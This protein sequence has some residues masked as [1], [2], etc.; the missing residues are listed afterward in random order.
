[1]TNEIKLIKERTEIAVAINGREMPVVK[2]DLVEADDYGLKSEPV[3]IDNGMFPKRA[4]FPEMP[5]MIHAEIRVFNDARK[6][7]FQGHGACISSSFGYYDVEEMLK[8]RN[9]PVIKAGSPVCIVIVNSET[10]TAYAPFV[11]HTTDHIS[12]HC[13]TPLSFKEDT[14]DMGDLYL[15]MAQIHKENKEKEMQE[16][17]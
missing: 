12:E 17:K 2:I 6:F 13:I 10:K 7:T 16:A 14:K 4:G 15:L 3:V 11:L 8:Y 5:Y 9:A 1:M